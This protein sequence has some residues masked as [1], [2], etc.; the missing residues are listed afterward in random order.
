MMT[1]AARSSTTASAG[2]N[3]CFATGRAVLTM[4]STETA[5]AMLADVGIAHPSMLHG[6]ALFTVLTVT[7]ISARINRPS[8]VVA[9][10]SIDLRMLHSSPSVDGRLNGRWHRPVYPAGDGSDQAVV[11][12]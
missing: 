9:T 5:N 10:S 7:E 6:L 1:I 2:T 12:P 8:T 4:A 3:L 11:H